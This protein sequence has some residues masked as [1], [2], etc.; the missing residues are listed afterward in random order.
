M[1]PDIEHR[2]EREEIA[3]N[4]REKLNTTF[5]WGSAAAAAL[6]GVVLQS[7]GAF[8]G[9]LVVTLGA[10]CYAGCIRAQPGGRPPEAGR[11][12]ARWRRP[13]PRRRP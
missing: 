9:T 6:L 12:G 2:E 1:S 11:D 5:A 13:A 8:W 4:A 3:M 10:C 7:W